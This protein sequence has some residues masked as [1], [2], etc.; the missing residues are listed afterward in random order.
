MKP[1]NDI[2]EK[3][4]AQLKRVNDFAVKGGTI[5]DYRAQVE[6]LRYLEHF[7]LADNNLSF[8]RKYDAQ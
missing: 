5:K 8:M 7:S 1:R 2:R 4:L 6:R 3:Y